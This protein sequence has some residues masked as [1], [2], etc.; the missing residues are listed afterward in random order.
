MRF[1]L[2]MRNLAKEGTQTNYSFE[3]KY[4]FS[5]A[6]ARTEVDF[7]QKARLYIF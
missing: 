7:S 2:A 4:V 1:G 3:I 5:Q 6:I